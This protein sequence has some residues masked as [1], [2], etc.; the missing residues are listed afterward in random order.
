[1]QMDP[2]QIQ[3]ILTGI[4]EGDHVRIARTAHFM[5]LVKSGIDG[6]ASL[7]IILRL[8]VY[9]LEGAEAKPPEI[10]P[11]SS[12]EVAIAFMQEASTNATHEEGSKN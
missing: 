4:F 8:D 12:L 1:M 5:G 9:G 10:D 2:L 3:K 11:L 6:M 7:G